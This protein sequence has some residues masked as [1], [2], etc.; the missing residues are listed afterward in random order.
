MG[1]LKEEFCRGLKA[2]ASSGNG[3]EEFWNILRRNTS[4]GQ[5][6]IWTRFDSFLY[7]DAND[8]ALSIRYPL[9]SYVEQCEACEADPRMQVKGCENI[10]EGW[11][12]MKLQGEETWAKR[13]NSLSDK[14]LERRASRTRLEDDENVFIASAF[15]KLFLIA[16]QPFREAPRFWTFQILFFCATYKHKFNQALGFIL[17]I[18]NFARCD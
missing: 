8:E 13:R 6:N 3:R 10:D 15:D 11:I 7:F 16:H 2:W 5:G 12:A 9:E 18:P 17:F 14:L 4:F 1:K